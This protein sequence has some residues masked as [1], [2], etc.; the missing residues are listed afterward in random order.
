MAAFNLFLGKV[1]I[2]GGLTETVVCSHGGNRRVV[3]LKLRYAK[4]VF[5]QSVKFHR[6][7]L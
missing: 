3:Y 5:D 7:S 2:E 4:L 1:K 6:Y